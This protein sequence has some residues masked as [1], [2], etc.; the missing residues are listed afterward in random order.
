MGMIDVNSSS[1]GM[2]GRVRMESICIKFP[3]KVSSAGLVEVLSSKD[4]DF[5]DYSGPRLHLQMVVIFALTQSL[6][7]LIFKYLGLPMFISQIVAGIILG[8]MVF[9]GH[10]SLIT[11]SDSSTQILGTLG[12]MGYIFYL[13]LSG[14]K[15]DLS[16]TQKAGKKAICIGCLTILVPVAFCLITDVI[17]SQNSDLIKNKNFFLALTYSGTSF[18]V[19]HGLLDELK[20]LNSELGR[21]GLSAAIVSD[22]VSFLLMTIGKRLRNLQ[23]EDKDALLGIR[24]MGFATAFVLLVLF[25]FRPLMRRMVKR[26]PQDGNIKSV[27]MYAVI[28]VF[29][30]SPAVS[31]IAN[32]FVTIGPYL[33]GLAVPVGPPL[34]AALVNKLDPLVSGLILPMFASTCAMRVNFSHVLLSNT[35]KYAKDQAIAALVTLVVKFGVSLLLPLLCKMPMAD[36]LALAFIMITKGIVEM[37]SYAIL[38]DQGVIS[39]DVFAIMAIFVVVL[40]ITVPFLVRQLYDPSRKFMGYEKRN[41]LNSKLNEDLRIIGCIHVPG[42]V[43]SLINILNLSCPT[44]ESAITVDVLHLV[45]LSGQATPI[46]IAHQKHSK[47]ISKKSYSENVVLAFGQFE[48]DHWEALSIH[49][50][51]AVSPPNLMYEDVCNLAMDRLTSFVILP[52]HRRWCIDGSVESEDQAIRSLNCDILERAPC[53]VGIL[54]EGFRTIPLGSLAKIAVIFLGGKDDREALALAKRISKD[55]RVLLTLIHLKATNS[56]GSILEDDDENNKMLDE[57]MLRIMKENGNLRYIEQHVHDGPETS[58]FLKSMVIDY[59]LVIVG[60]RYKVEDPR[61]CGLEE[62]TEFPE[63]GILGDLLSTSDFG[64]HYSLLIVQQQ[65]LRINA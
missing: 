4:D 3:P 33:F 18:P 59:Q 56:L 32:M 11:M 37:G 47:T 17:L 9:K 52:F 10:H 2:E 30:I 26:T 1:T 45:R 65:Q 21:L 64:G 54:V 58:E 13:F 7:N 27:Y 41:I 57:E 23:L 36:S 48:R 19:I 16:L 8:P 14:V 39:E 5:M 24:D 22:L 62:W 51:T 61:T 12:S 28:I 29:L 15:M 34:G 35:S 43:N 55:Q 53:S 46:F 20:I 40:A 60:R 42:N 50:F 6:H 25:V 63:I 49:V 44:K 38:F 31:G